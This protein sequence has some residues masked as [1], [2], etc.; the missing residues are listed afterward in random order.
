VSSET[1]KI[2]TNQ[3]IIVS[4]VTKDNTAKL[5]Y[6]VTNQIPELVKKEFTTKS[7]GMIARGKNQYFP[8]FIGATEAEMM[9]KEQLFRKV[10]DTIND[11]FGNNIIVIGVLPKTGTLLDEMHFVGENFQ[12][13]QE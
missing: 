8:V 12:I 9:Q 7:F 3:G 4:K 1:Y 11:F 6:I 2:I 5:F 10:G 13:N